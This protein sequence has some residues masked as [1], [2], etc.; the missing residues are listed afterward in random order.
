[1]NFFTWNIGFKTNNKTNNNKNIISKIYNLFNFIKLIF[2][3]LIVDD[4]DYD[5]VLL[6]QEMLLVED[7]ISIILK[8]N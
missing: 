4:I 6:D 5:F 3:T 1:M 8:K 2:K 7:Y